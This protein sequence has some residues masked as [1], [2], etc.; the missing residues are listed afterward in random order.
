MPDSNSKRGAS[1]HDVTLLLQRASVGDRQAVNALMPIVYR[2]LH[3]LAEARMRH[4]RYGQSLQPT[5][6][7]HEAWMRIQGGVSGHRPQNRPHFFAIAARA[8]RQVLIDRAR[9]YNALKRGGHEMRVT[10]GDDVAQQGPASLDVLAIDRALKKLA[11]LDKR[12][13]KVV[14]LRCFGDMTIED[15]A[16]ALAVSTGTVKRDWMMAR[17]FLSSELEGSA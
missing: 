11:A 15:I 8:M 10:F 7:V 16:K 2:E 17:A 1:K 9:E 14:E 3:R 6:L 13:A 12:Q 5:G 4:E